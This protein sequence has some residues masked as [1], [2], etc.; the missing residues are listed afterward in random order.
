MKVQK[1]FLTSALQMFHEE[2]NAF[3]A[4]VQRMCQRIY[5]DQNQN[6]LT[7]LTSIGCVAIDHYYTWLL[8]KLLKTHQQGTLFHQTCFIITSNQVL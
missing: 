6:E 7:P 4:F 3:S 5:K 2:R 8:V 1:Y